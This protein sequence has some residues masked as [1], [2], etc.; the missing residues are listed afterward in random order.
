MRWI[1]RL[2]AA[3]SLT[4]G[5]SGLCYGG[6]NSISTTARVSVSTSTATTLFTADQQIKRTILI[7]NNTDYILIG[8]ADTTFST[9]ETT[10]TFRL[11]GS[12][13]FSPDGTL[14]FTGSMKAIAG[15]SGAI[16]IDVMR[17]K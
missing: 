3:L 15:G 4:L 16:N 1:K 2:C 12:T 14:P 6:S 5:V 13:A 7:N 8:D 17:V 11:P 9:S 10:G